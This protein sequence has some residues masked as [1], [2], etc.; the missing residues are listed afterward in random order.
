LHELGAYNAIAEMGQMLNAD[1]GVVQSLQS[2]AA[3]LKANINFKIWNYFV[4]S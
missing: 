1:K 4:I 2:K 3:T